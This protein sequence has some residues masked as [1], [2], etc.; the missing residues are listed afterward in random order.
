MGGQLGVYGAFVPD[1][2]VAR[3]A[4][5]PASE[6]RARA[7]GTELVRPKTHGDMALSSDPGSGFE[8]HRFRGNPQTS[9]PRARPPRWPVIG[10]PGE[11]PA[12]DQRLLKNGFV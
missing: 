8:W 12:I 7:S 1:L 2:I 3:W 5:R 11:V 9:K 6:C 10:V 4:K